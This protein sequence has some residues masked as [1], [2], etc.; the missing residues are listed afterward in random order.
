MTPTLLI[1]AEAGVFTAPS[2]ETGTLLRAYDKATGREVGA[3]FVP[4]PV[5]GSPMTYML[6]GR[7]HI[8]LASRGTLLAYRLPPDGR[9]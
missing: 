8:A 7:Q 5:S 2:G 6:S 1:A 9:Q 3:V 4:G